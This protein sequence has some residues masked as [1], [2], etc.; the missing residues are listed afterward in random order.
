VRAPLMSHHLLG[1]SSPQQSR[2]AP[3]I[4]ENLR[5]WGFAAPCPSAARLGYL[6]AGAFSAQL[7]SIREK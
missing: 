4:A 3:R 2:L 7:G 6:R 1:A 5:P